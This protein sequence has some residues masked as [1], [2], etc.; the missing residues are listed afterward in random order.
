MADEMPCP[1]CGT[2]NPVSRTYCVKCAHELRRPAE[3][4][5]A[6]GIVCPMCGARN[7]AA[8]T[9]CSTAD[10]TWVVID[11]PETD[12]VRAWD[13]PRDELLG[14]CDRAPEGRVEHLPA[15]R[16][17]TCEPNAFRI[18][19]SSIGPTAQGPHR[20]RR[21][22]VARS[23]EPVTAN[24]AGAY[25]ARSGGSATRCRSSSVGRRTAQRPVMAHQL[26]A[27]WVASREELGGPPVAIVVT[28]PA[29]YGAYKIDLLE[30]RAIR[31]RASPTRRCSP[32]RRRPRVQYARQ[33]RV[34]RPGPWSPVYD[35][36][37]GLPSRRRSC[38]RP[39]TVLSKLGRPEDRDRAARWHR[40]RR[41]DFQPSH[42][43]GPLERDR[44]RLRTRRRMAAIAAPARGMPARQ[45]RCRPTRTLSVAVVLPGP[46]TLQTEMLTRG[47]VR[48]DRPR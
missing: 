46:S 24:A 32:S 2:S 41:G 39:R 10:T 7:P 1:N 45:E 13:R 8:E 29:S 15:R 38:A 20:R 17:R 33:E 9:F 36:G 40:L 22:A 19:R 34:H 44:G 12:G 3:P 23:H 43:H 16:S 30:P 6:D 25:V 21:G 5:G 11:R 28:H 37:G 35:F 31:R 4:R 14:R 42:D 27:S 48:G 26:R 18:G 47:G